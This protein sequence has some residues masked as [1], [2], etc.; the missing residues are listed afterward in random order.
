MMALID[1]DLAKAGL[2]AIRATDG[3]RTWEVG[4]GEPE[5]TIT[6]PSTYELMRLLGSR[7]SLAQMRQADITGDLD[8]FLP[9]IAHLPLPEHDLIE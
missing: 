2:P 3:T 6:A 1:A 5:L 8:R 4:T 7:R 9:G